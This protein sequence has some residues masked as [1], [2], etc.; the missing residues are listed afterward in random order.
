MHAVP[1]YEALQAEL[2]FWPR[3]HCTASA[4]LYPANVSSIN[5]ATSTTNDEIKS[6]RETLNC[7]L[8]TQKIH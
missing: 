2:W 4:E 7:R 6:K 5:Y 8:D 1:A 3:T